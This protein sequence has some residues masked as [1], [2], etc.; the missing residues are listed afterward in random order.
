MTVKD[1][2]YGRCSVRAYLPGPVE[3]SVVS[4]LLEAA[5]RAPTAMHGEPWRF[6]VVQDMDLLKRVSD[7]AKALFV[8]ETV[9]LHNRPEGLNAFSQPGFNVFYDAGTLIVICAENVGHF[10]V[11]DCWLAAE[12]MM[13]AAHAMGLGTC[14]IGS[15]VSALNLPELKSE[16]GIPPETTAVA[17]IIVGSPR[18]G[19]TSSARKS[20][21]ILKWC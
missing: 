8:A 20:P 21:Q 5:V 11:A 17:P 14:V 7:R 10:E 2:I 15:A 4:E 18:G 6:I 13:L 19:L 3:R 16:L 12:N 1:A 9:R